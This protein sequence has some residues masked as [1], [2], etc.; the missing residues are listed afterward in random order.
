MSVQ[1]HQPLF[2]DLLVRHEAVLIEPLDLAQSLVVG[3][4]G[5]RTNSFLASPIEI[6]RV[7]VGVIVAGRGHFENED[8][9]H[10]ES[11][12]EE[13]GMGLGVALGLDRV[14]RLLT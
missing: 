3:V 13:A 6:D 12:A 9:D 1:P 2:V 4:G 8:L 11:L 14:R 10:L 7:C 5:A